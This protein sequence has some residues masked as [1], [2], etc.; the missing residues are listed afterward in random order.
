MRQQEAG[1]YIIPG[2]NF[3]PVHNMKKILLII[4]LCLPLFLGSAGSVF[5]ATVQT[6]NNLNLPDISIDEVLGNIL[7]LVA[8][9]IAWVAV[10]VIVIGGIMWMTAGGDEEQVARARKMIIAAIVGLIIVGA[11]AGLVNFI[12]DMVFPAS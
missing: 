10:L 12:L 6:P 9:I 3:L 5:S 7:N 8:K 4:L 2:M 11:A 1:K